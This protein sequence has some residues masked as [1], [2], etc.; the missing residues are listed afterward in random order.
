MDIFFYKTSPKGVIRILGEDAEDYLQSQWSVNLRKLPTG[1]I[2]YGLRLS[3]KGK[4]LAD[5]YILRLGDEE[6]LLFSKD[7]KGDHIISLLNKNIVADEVEFINLTENWE[8]ISFWNQGKDTNL[9]LEGVAKPEKNQ[10][11][12]MEDSFYFEDFR[13]FPGAFIMLLSLRSKWKMNSGLIPKNKNE[14]EGLRI[15][16]GEVSIPCEIGPDDLPQEGKLEKIA[17]DFDKGCYL[18][19][20]VM[21]RIHAIGRVRRRTCP[22]S[23]AS[24]EMPTIPCPV[25]AGEKKVGV[26][27]SM[28]QTENGNSIGMAL[29]HEKGL[30]TL[31]SEGLQIEGFTDLKLRKV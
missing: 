11:T 1:G 13:A 17:V 14:Y 19:H 31:N 4:V 7:C 24:N 3:T 21:A 15:R 30:D 22:V 20:E 28:I 10:F 2:R 27:R 9:Y 26:L 18:G 8:I 5:S 29:I 16:A 25:F 6:F 23:W 12:T